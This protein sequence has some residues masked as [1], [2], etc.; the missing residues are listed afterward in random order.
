M[1]DHLVSTVMYGILSWFRITGPVLAVFIIVGVIAFFAL[2]EAIL[3]IRWSDKK[4]REQEW[5]DSQN[6]TVHNWTTFW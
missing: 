3:F 4:Q 5:I 6:H 1:F 2:I